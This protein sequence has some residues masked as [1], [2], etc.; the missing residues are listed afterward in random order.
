MIIFADIE[1][2]NLDPHE[3]TK[4]P[5]LVKASDFSS[6]GVADFQEVLTSVTDAKEVFGEPGNTLVFHNG[7]S[8]DEVVLKRFGADFE[9]YS[10]ID[11]LVLSRL[12]FPER[13]SHALEAWGRDL[14]LLK[15]PFDF[16]AWAKT[17]HFPTME[18][19]EYC[20][21]DVQITYRVF[22]ACLQRAR[23][24]PANWIKHHDFEVQIQRLIDSQSPFTVDSLKFMKTLR[25][26]KDSCETLQDL[27]QLE[28]PEI[29]LPKSRVK[30]P[31]KKQFTVTG[32]L[33]KAAYAYFPDIQ[34]TPGTSRYTFKHPFFKS[35]YA[36]PWNSPLVTHEPVSLDRP[37]G[38]KEALKEL[39]WEPTMW[40]TNSEGKRTTPKLWD[41]NTETI[42]PGIL[43]VVS[44]DVADALYE[45]LTLKHRVRMLEGWLIRSPT[46]EDGADDFKVRTPA[47]GLGTRTSRYAHYSLVNVPRPGTLYGTECRS[48]L[49][50]RVGEV[51]VGWD[52]S[53]LEARIEAHYTRPYDSFKAE[54]LISGDIHQDLADACGEGVTRDQAKAVKYALTYGAGL[55]RIQSMLGEE[56][57][58]L[59]Y[60]TFWDENE[61]L[62]FL[63]GQARAEFKK[64]GYVRTLDGRCSVPAGENS[65]FNT[66]LQ[67][68]GAI[69]MK[70]ASIIAHDAVRKAGILEDRA[71]CII[72]YHDEEQWSA[73]PSVA[74]TVGE[75]GVQSVQAAGEFYELNVPLTAEFKIGSN[76]AETH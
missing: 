29:P 4:I 56:L 46:S 27:I 72:R 59:V 24:L 26:L 65:A 1:T 58:Q 16:E 52:A 45:G 19:I 30:H 21:R 47:A 69:C 12:L 23:D 44:S 49:G 75:L 48:L 70:R 25:S 13:K 5:V 43:D 76:W 32:K 51:Q 36:L 57:G 7:T 67:T 18:V 33:T 40:N 73:H 66:K 17:D 42:C 53:G 37:D 31:P 54:A 2:D 20:I 28:L 64:H 35:R 50:P 55:S 14:G 41:K 62:Q 6:R 39:G 74:D 34:K 10:L 68:G 15:K 8:Y 38:I 11:T 71:N 63:I 3:V 22:E 60:S 9:Q 61:A